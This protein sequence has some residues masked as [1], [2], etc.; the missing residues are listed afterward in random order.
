MQKAYRKTELCG[1]QMKNRPFQRGCLASLFTGFD[2][3]LGFVSSCLKDLQPVYDYD[4][5]SIVPLCRISAKRL[6]D[7]R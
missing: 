3:R 7:T 1:K 2:E 4:T 5:L 6:S